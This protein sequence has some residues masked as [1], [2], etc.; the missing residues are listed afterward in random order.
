MYIKEN[1]V[2]TKKVEIPV[3]NGYTIK[4]DICYS[5]WVLALPIQKLW[6]DACSTHTTYTTTIFE[7]AQNI[8]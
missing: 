6:Y 1:K 8:I 2:K 4:A 5:D 3:I 7:R